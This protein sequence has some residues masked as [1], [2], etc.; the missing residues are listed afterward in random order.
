MIGDMGILREKSRVKLSK[1]S[2]DGLRYKFREELWE[3][4]REIGWLESQNS[5]GV[6]GR[7]FQLQD[8]LK[9]N[10]LRNLSGSVEGISARKEKSQVNLMN[11]TC[12]RLLKKSPED[13]HQKSWEHFL[14]YLA[15][16]RIKENIQDKF[17]MESRDN[18]INSG[19]SLTR[20]SW[21]NS[22]NPRQ[23]FR[24]NST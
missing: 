23:N 20:T 12:K 7:K 1:K 16:K 18:C 3:L 4:P 5:E 17:R 14:F 15:L 13:L 6:S 10:Y 9:K 11:K 19:R 22:K 21:M 2:L 8:I 24:R